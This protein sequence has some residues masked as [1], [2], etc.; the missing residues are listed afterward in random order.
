MPKA[1]IVFNAIANRLLTHQSPTSHNSHPTTAAAMTFQEVGEWVVRQIKLPVNVN[2]SNVAFVVEIADKTAVAPLTDEMVLALI[3]DANLKQQPA[4]SAKK[5]KKPAAMKRKAV[6]SSESESDSVSASPIA[7][8][9]RA[10]N[11]P[12]PSPTINKHALSPAPQPA[13]V[14]E[15]ETDFTMGDGRTLE[16]MIKLL[17]DGGEANTVPAFNAFNAFNADFVDFGSAPMTPTAPHDF[18]APFNFDAPQDLTD[19]LDDDFIHGVI[20]MFQAGGDMAI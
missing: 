9:K 5:T 15:F 12:P 4:T 10:K 1:N 18:S 20:E 7:S 13:Q 2:K 8:P 17:L 11:T 19:A 14:S 6:A 16:E 3:Q